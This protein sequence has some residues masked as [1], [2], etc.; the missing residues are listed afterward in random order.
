[1]KG[2]ALCA[3]QFSQ[4]LVGDVLDHPLG[5]Q[6]VRQL[7]QAPPRERQPVLSRGGLGDLLDLPPLRQRE[8][9][10]VPAGV[11]RVQRVKAVG[12]EVVQHVAT[13]S[14]LVK[15][16]LAI[17]GTLMR[18]ADHST[19]CARRQVTTDPDPRRTIRLRR[20]PSSSLISRTRTGPA[21]P[22][23]VPRS[24]SARNPRRP[25]WPVENRANVDSYGTSEAPPQT[26]EVG[27]SAG[28]IV[29]AGSS[30]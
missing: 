9:R 4:A 19:I 26:I 7:G 2:H 24:T 1:M 21:I 13:R 15:A 8:H 17:W 25:P 14:S 30:S 22:A 27:G 28:V 20:L 5:D 11:P 23:S 3:Q 10:R 6:E 29:R 16:S 18:C 12:I